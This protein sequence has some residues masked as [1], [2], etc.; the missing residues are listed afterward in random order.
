MFFAGMLQATGTSSQK[1]QVTE[2]EKLVKKNS[3][4]V[5]WS[6]PRI[7]IEVFR[8][9]NP[10]LSTLFPD[11]HICCVTKVA[12]AHGAQRRVLEFCHSRPKEFLA[13]GFGFPPP[14]YTKHVGTQ[15]AEYSCN[16]AVAPRKNAPTPLQ[17][18]STQPTICASPLLSTLRWWCSR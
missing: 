16:I 9:S 13:Q 15:T 7:F 11:L 6:K 2:H 5:F 8:K 17:R 18:P 3:D 10:I 4:W 14:P 12:E 1:T